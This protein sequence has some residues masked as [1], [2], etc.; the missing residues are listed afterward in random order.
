MDLPKCSNKEL[1]DFDWSLKLALSSDK[2]SGLR[3]PL[4]QLKLD[5]ATPTG[6]SDSTLLELDYAELNG[7]LKTLT[8]AQ[9]VICISLLSRSLYL[10]SIYYYGA[11]SLTHKFYL[12]SK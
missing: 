1:V 11:R 10:L 7:L 9:K 6:Q 3:K 8:A 12:E 5:T 2:I 4:V